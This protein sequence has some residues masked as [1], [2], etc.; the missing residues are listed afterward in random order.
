[1]T[2]AVTFQFKEPPI[3]TTMEKNDDDRARAA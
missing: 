1:M 2:T 3:K